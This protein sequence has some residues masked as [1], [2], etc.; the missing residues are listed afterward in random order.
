MILEQIRSQ[1]IDSK[2]YYI[3]LDEVQLL[4]QFEDVLNSLLHIKM[5]M[6]M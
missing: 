3:F 1:L 5:L 6:Y 2:D 4:D